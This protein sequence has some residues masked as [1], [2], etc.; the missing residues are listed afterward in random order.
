MNTKFQKINDQIGRMARDEMI[1]A[2]EE[3]IVDYSNPDL[4]HVYRE[5]NGWHCGRPSHKISQYGW[6]NGHALYKIV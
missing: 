5:I 6:M 1:E 2:I 4:L 3:K